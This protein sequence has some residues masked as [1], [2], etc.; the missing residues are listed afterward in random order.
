MNDAASDLSKLKGRAEGGLAEITAA[1]R[2][3][4][5][6]RPEGVRNSDVAR[7]LGLQTHVGGGQRNHL[8]HAVLTELVRNGTVTRDKHGVHIYYVP[9]A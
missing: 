4:V 2:A 9:N 5:G 1:V 7:E 3:L 6:S 8:T